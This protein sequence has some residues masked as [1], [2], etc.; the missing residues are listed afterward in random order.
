VAL[1]T[2]NDNT[3]VPGPPPGKSMGLV[4]RDFKALPA[5]CYAAAPAFDIPLLTDDDIEAALR[6]QN[7]GATM[8]L[9]HIRDIADNGKPIPS[10]DQNGQGYCWAYSTTSASMLARAAAGMPYVRLSG[11]MIGCLV[12]G[13]RDQGGW[14]AQSVSFAA[15]NGIASTEFWKEKSMARSN[16]NAEMRANAKQ[17]QLFE[18]MELDDGGPELKRQMATCLLMGIPYASD[19]NWW[20]H[21]VCACRLV[22]WNP[23]K[24]LIWNSWSNSWSD[25]GMGVLEGNRAIPNGAIAVRVSRPSNN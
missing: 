20:S 4:P 3:P 21:S 23:L 19:H 12:K 9:Q 1:V 25:N 5:G 15:A 10:L 14:N 24:V 16:D 22:S 8:S 7:S 11:H 13:Y 18:F 2:I 6:A 17:H